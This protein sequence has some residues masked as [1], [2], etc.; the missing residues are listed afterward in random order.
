[1]TTNAGNTG[2]SSNLAAALCYLFGF[3][4]GVA[5]L[6]IAPYNQ[7]KEIRFHA[8]Q[9]IFLSIA[10]IVFS[11]AFNIL[12]SMGPLYTLY[13]LLPLINLAFLVLWV[14][15]MYMAYQGKRFVL[16]VVGPL[17]EQQA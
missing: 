14:Y 17:A 10:W 9:S 5:F 7:D 4:S 1:M 2:L 6:V 16:P 11:A 13:F 8:F 12:V 3:V 15:L